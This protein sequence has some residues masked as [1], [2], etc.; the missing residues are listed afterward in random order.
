[1][2]NE[3]QK[4]PPAQSSGINP[5]K[6]ANYQPPAPATV[7]SLLTSNKITTNI[8][9]LAQKV[10]VDLSAVL[11]FVPPIFQKASAKTKE[12]EIANIN[13]GGSTD[14][15]F[16]TSQIMFGVPILDRWVKLYDYNGNNE[17]LLEYVFY[18][19]NKKVNWNITPVLGFQGTTAKELQSDTDYEISI[20]GGFISP[21]GYWTRPKQQLNTL[22][23]I[24]N[25]QNPTSQFPQP[26]RTIQIECP[27]FKYIDPEIEFMIIEDYKIMEDEKHMNVIGFELMGKTDK[28][29]QI[30][31]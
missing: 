29:L 22:L 31:Y 16:L 1:M 10:G 23:R 5:N 3:I 18:T 20:K 25:L 24:L 19:I 28:D 15:F 12:M 26:Y 27:F 6:L 30:I 13:A 7:L 4:Q 21:N 9:S 17:L 11:A 8:T 2:A 14:P